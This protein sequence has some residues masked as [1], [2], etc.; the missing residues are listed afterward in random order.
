VS[1][2]EEILS[3]ITIPPLAR[4][5]QHFARPVLHDVAAS[6][7]QQI[8][9]P[10]MLE[11][12]KTGDRVAIAVGSR[13]IAN[14][15]LIVATIVDCLKEVG[16]D[17]FIVPA[18]GSHGGATTSGQAAVLADYGITAEGVG[19][20]V[21]SSL[22][23][24]NLASLAEPVYFDR[25]AFTAEHTIAIG[26][27][28]LHP[29]FRGA[30]ESGLVKMIAIGLG[31]QKGAE[32]CHGFGIENMAFHIERIARI[33]LSRANI[34]GGVA[35]LENAYDETC[36]VVALPATEILAAE[37]NLLLE[38]KMHMPK[39]Y[40]NQ[41]DVLI[42]D[43]MG[44][45]I[46]GTGMDP[47]IIERYTTPTL[48]N[49]NKFQRIVV[50]DLTPESHGNFNGA[51]LADICTRRLFNKMNF[52]ATYPNQLTSR[53]VASGRIPMVMDNDRLAIQAA[54]KTCCGID[55]ANLR[56]VRIKNT[57]EL[58]EI[59]ISPALLPEAVNNPQV[60]IL[61]SPQDISFDASGNLLY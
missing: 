12:I 17:P 56:M 43:E 19:A 39:I 58:A 20:P 45:N 5:R 21:I 38:A 28:K 2:V 37:P 7:R 49:T 13:G 41:V 32:L 10:G 34:L 26:R 9:K 55:Q 61:D 14:L 24:T 42:I 59:M 31:K 18:M 4:A 29:A 25:Q 1:A 3:G 57:M 16:A 36:Q 51:G 53:V 33:A 60:E 48:S 6:V 27:I 52:A 23:V 54:I 30:Y 11:K 15:R 35:L 50:R 8:K 22:E 44:K 46:S 40:F 47:N